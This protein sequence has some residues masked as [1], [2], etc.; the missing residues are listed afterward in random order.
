MGYPPSIAGR[1][2]VAIDP[3]K[4]ECSVASASQ[5]VERFVRSIAGVG[6]VIVKVNS[7]LRGNY[8]LLRTIKEFGFRTFA[9]L[10]LSD[11]PTTME[12]DSVI[13]RGYEPD[14]VTVMCSAGRDSLQT[15]AQ[16]FN[17]T[18]TEVLGVTILTSLNERDCQNLYYEYDT[19][20]VVL[21]HA[22]V[23]I[24]SG[25]SGLVCSTLEIGLLRAAF[26][27][28][29]TLNVPGIRPAWHRTPGNHKKRVGTPTEAIRAG[30]T[31]IIVGSPITGNAS[32][33]EAIEKILEEIS[34]AS[35]D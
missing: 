4:G 23:A 15:I 25:L 24:K 11:T 28:R 9:D 8:Q 13:L 6:D 5:Y 18:R 19:G 27:E 2:V 20:K 33:R 17:G 29:C 14:F 30:A 16:I 34:I 22:D 35:S 26:K 31:R 3:P 32:P 12:S 1:L 21:R 7:A 10:K